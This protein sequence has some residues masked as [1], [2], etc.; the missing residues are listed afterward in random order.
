[1]ALRVPFGACNRKISTPA[2]HG[3]LLRSVNYCTIRHNAP[4]HLLSLVAGRNISR[5][6]RRLPPVTVTTRGFHLTSAVLA[7]RK[8][9]FYEVLGV[10]KDA[11]KADIKKSFY[12]LAKEF[13]PD[14]NKD[15]PNAAKKFGEVGVGA[16]I[17]LRVGFKCA[18]S[19]YALHCTHLFYRCLKRMKFFLMTKKRSVTIRWAML[20]SIQ[21]WLAMGRVFQV[22]HRGLKICSTCSRVV[23][24][25]GHL[26]REVLVCRVGMTYRS[27]CIYMR[28]S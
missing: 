10:S 24:A 20:E 6:Q 18:D 9:D 12:K 16:N 2:V 3:I 8:R 19:D 4:R 13:H 15:D 11:S 17:C 1:M 7:E 25:G 22:V 26:A 5:G 21:I 28:C 23:V 27:I 14:T